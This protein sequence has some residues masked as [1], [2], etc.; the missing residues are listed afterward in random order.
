MCMYNF[1]I[2]ILHTSVVKLHSCIIKQITENWILTENGV[3]WI[4]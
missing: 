2:I 4:P 3:K 1:D